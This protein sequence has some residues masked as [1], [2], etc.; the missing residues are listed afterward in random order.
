MPPHFTLIT[1]ESPAS[2]QTHSEVLGLHHVNLGGDMSAHVTWGAGL[3]EV[4]DLGNKM[5]CNV[6]SWASGLRYPIFSTLELDV[7]ITGRFSKVH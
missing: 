7:F 6:S 1:S 5:S 3:N 2:T 4:H